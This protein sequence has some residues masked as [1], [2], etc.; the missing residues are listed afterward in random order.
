MAS[1][2]FREEL[3]AKTGHDLAWFSSAIAGLRGGLTDAIARLRDLQSPKGA[4]GAA[5]ETALSLMKVAD[6]LDP[7]GDKPL[8]TLILV[9]R[10]PKTFGCSLGYVDRDGCRD[11]DEEWRRLGE[12]MGAK[13]Y[14]LLSYDEDVA[15]VRLPDLDRN[16]CHTSADTVMSTGFPG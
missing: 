16:P 5:R 3:V 4:A 15:M 14:E 13:G 7:P 1:K 8:T 9:S 10:T 12:M 2:A 6:L 11:A